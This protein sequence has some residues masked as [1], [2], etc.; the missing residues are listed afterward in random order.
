MPRDL[1]GRLRKVLRALATEPRPHGAEPLKGHDLYRL[2][3]GDWRII[4]AIRDAEL[5]VLIVRI[6]ARGQAY[7]DL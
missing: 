2:R 5:L 4:Y 7:R 1:A 3:L 6:A